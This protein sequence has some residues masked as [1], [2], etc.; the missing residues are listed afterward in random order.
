MHVVSRWGGRLQ[1]GVFV[2]VAAAVVILTIWNLNEEKEIG[3]R[4]GLYVRIDGFFHLL[5]GIS[6]YVK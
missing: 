5:G 4:S 6:S 3:D 2:L 1:R